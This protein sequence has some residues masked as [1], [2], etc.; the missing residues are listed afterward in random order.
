MHIYIIQFSLTLSNGLE[1]NMQKTKI[2]AGYS[3][4]YLKKKSKW[5]RGHGQWCRGFRK[6]R[7]FSCARRWYASNI[8]WHLLNMYSKYWTSKPMDPPVLK[9]LK[10][11]IIRL[12]RKGVLN[13]FATVI[14]CLCVSVCLALRARIYRCDFW[15]VD[16]V[17]G[18]LGQVE[19]SRFCVKGQGHQV[20]FSQWDGP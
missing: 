5:H 18:Y 14:L 6:L 9:C 19:R 4:D 13:S 2:I 16:K 20:F 10:R 17:V 15:H 11:I 8:L 12:L 1:S 7:W 3:Q